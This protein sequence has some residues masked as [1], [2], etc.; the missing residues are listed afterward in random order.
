MLVA[1]IK[2]SKTYKPQYNKLLKLIR[3]YFK[4]MI[5]QCNKAPTEVQVKEANIKHAQYL[6]LAVD[7]HKSVVNRYK[8]STK[9]LTEFFGF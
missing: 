5:F 2:T 9:I 3:K 7:R 6:S 8:K 4:D 1:D